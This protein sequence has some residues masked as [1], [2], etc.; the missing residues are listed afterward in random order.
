MS[1]KWIEEFSPALRF[2]ICPL[3][4]SRP[5]QKNQQLHNLP[6]FSS[7]FQLENSDSSTTITRTYLSFPGGWHCRVDFLTVQGLTVTSLTYRVCVTVRLQDIHSSFM[8]SPVRDDSVNMQMCGW[9]TGCLEIS[10]EA[11]KQWTHTLDSFRGTY[12]DNTPQCVSCRLVCFPR[13][14]SNRLVVTEVFQVSLMILQRRWGH[15]QASGP[16]C[17]S[18]AS[19]CS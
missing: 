8:I 14:I 2:R 4:S 7:I 9:N 18:V 1:D 12:F 5:L 3:V 16:S 13:S 11:V 17:R 15:S 10:V 19:P 6:M